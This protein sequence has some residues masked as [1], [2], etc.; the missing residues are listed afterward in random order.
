MS[1]SADGWISWAVRDPGPPDKVYSEINSLQGVIPHSM[2]GRYTT[3]RQM[4]FNRDRQAN[5]RYTVYAAR[6]WNMSNLFKGIA[7]QHYSVFSS[8]W[9]SGSR[10]PNISFFTMEGEGTQGTPYDQGQHEVLTQVIKEL[11]DFKRW[12]QLIRRPLTVTDLKAQ[13][14]EHCECTRW[15]SD[16]TSCPSHRVLWEQVIQ[17]V[18]VPGDIPGVVDDPDARKAIG[19]VLQSMNSEAMKQDGANKFIIEIQYLMTHGRE[20]EAQQRLEDLYAYFGVPTP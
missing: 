16:P 6:S 2:E 14:Y 1:I 8:C 9:T 13:L 7:I 19:A 10:F 18:N 4:L 5:G 20:A 11:R 12:P 15:G 17:A 3:A